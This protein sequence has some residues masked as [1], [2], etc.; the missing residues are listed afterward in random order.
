MYTEIKKTY[1]ERDS[2]NQRHAEDV[3]EKENKRKFGSVLP[4]FVRGGISR[5]CGLVLSYG[6]SVFY[7]A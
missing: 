1:C 6:R 7:A 4:A 2:N 3:F 5:V